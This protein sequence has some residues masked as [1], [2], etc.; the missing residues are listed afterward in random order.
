MSSSGRGM[1]PIGSWGMVI[2]IAPSA[3]DCTEK[4]NVARAAPLWPQFLQW[5][6]LMSAHGS[7]SSAGVRSS[8]RFAE[9]VDAIRALRDL[10]S[11]VREG[12][13]GKALRDKLVD[14]ARVLFAADAVA[15]WRLESREQTWCIA[16]AAGLS[17]SFSAVSV[18]VSG[19]E[20]AASSVLPGPLLVRT[21]ATGRC[22]AR[23][24]LT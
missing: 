19:N 13:R 11:L 2:I 3:L 16:A 22:D 1:L 20:A 5:R 24:A 6:A 23:R 12:I 21:C 8:G 7:A 17:G 18:P 9:G 14:R 10:A 15:L 4:L